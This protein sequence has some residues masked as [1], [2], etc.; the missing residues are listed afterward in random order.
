LCSPNAIHGQGFSGK[1]AGGK[2]KIALHRKLPA[3]IHL[4]TTSFAVTASARDKN[5]ADVAQSLSDILETEL[6]KDDKRLHVE[7]KSPE[8]LISCTLNHYDIPPPQTSTRNDTV[9]QR[10]HTVE[11]PK[12]YYRITGVLELSYQAKDQKSGRVIDSENI[13]SK[14]SREFESGS[15]EASDKSIASRVVNPFKHLAG[16]KTEDD[17]P[18]P[19]QIEVRQLL[20]HQAVLQIAARLVSTEEDV[21][22]NL[23]RGKLDSANKLAE[24]GLW[25]RNLETLETMT[26][27]PDRREDAYRI[28]NIGVANEALGYQS[29]DR[30]TAKKFL[31][32]AAINYGKA[33]DARPDEKYFV[34]PQTRIETAVAYYKKLSERANAGTQA[35]AQSES[36]VGAAS[37]QA[38]SPAK[39]ASVEAAAAHTATKSGAS[40]ASKPNSGS[41]G[42]GATRNAPTA[43]KSV[44]T[45][46]VSAPLAPALTNQKVIDM[47]KGGVDEENIIAT[48]QESA[49]TQFDLSPD[50]QIGLAKNGVKGKILAAMRSRARLPNRTKAV[51]PR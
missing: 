13:S 23:A 47:L 16:K 14:Y 28:Y 8:L 7:K 43:A 15:N 24:S 30:A 11:V 37:A 38:G 32:E 31:E 19:S 17:A 40:P 49:V 25:S 3:A 6:L 50:G 22:V 12:Q 10:G 48:I 44:G 51:T 1:I 9:L 35:A 4:N 45:S 2:T 18:P 34:Q 46:S 21:E 39:R 27:L 41:S 20:I 36:S 29:E 5:Q 33:I 42:T 26:P